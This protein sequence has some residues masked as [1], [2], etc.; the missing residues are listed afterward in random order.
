MP[1]H[2][3][4]NWLLLRG[5]CREAAHWG[6]FPALLQSAF[7]DSSI[8]TIDLPGTGCFHRQISPKRIEEI[9]DKVRGHALHAGLLNRRLSILALS[10]GGMVA[11]EWLHRYPQDIAE[12]ALVNTSFASLN[13]FYQR[14][15]WQSYRQFLKILLERDSYR[16]ELAIIRLISNRR[17]QDRELALIWTAIQKERPI[18]VKN[19]FRQISAAARY[20]PSEYQYQAPVLLLNGRGDRLVAPACSEAIHSQWGIDIFSHPWAGHDLILDDGAWV[21]NRLKDWV[22]PLT[23]G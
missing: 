9:T 12:L 4:R 18:S 14:L 16:R 2:I 3:P 23:N 1:D 6:E 7:P 20:R 22:N 15:R 10:L 13:P 21:V 19:A 8:N 11:W 17:D 5:L